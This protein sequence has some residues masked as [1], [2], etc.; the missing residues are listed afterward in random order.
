MP[1]NALHRYLPVTGAL[2]ASL[3]LCG[4]TALAGDETA[5]DNIVRYTVD[6]D[7]YSVKDAL[8]MAIVNQ[9]LVISSESHI[10]EMLKRTA[11]DLGI[12]SRVYE[13]AVAFEFCSANYSRRMMEADPHNIVFCP[14]VISVYQIA[15]QPETHVAYDRPRRPDAGEAV[16]GALAEVAG[17]LDTIAREATE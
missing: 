8:E 1:C 15:G 6:A 5:A 4:N 14:F 3:S 13:H 17:L 9:G 11:A 7:F 12:D 16:S 10:D 2:L